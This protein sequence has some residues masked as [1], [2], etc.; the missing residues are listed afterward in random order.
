MTDFV[1]HGRTDGRTHG[2]TDARTYE[3]DFVDASTQKPL[4]GQQ[5][6]SK[7]VFFPEKKPTSY[8]YS[9]SKATVPF[10][11]SPV[12]NESYGCLLYDA[13]DEN[14]KFPNCVTDFG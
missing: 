2:R 3:H 10:V 4:K 5:Y 14:P 11:M 12:P 8:N 6:S 9:F 1:T 13:V 7:V